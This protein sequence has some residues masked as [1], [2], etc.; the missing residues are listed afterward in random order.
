MSWSVDGPGISA[1]DSLFTTPAGHTGVTFVGIAG[2][3]GTFVY[4]GSSPNVLAVGGTTLSL[5]AAGNYGGETVWNDGNGG[6]SGGGGPDPNYPVKPGPDVAYNAG[7]PVWV[8]DS[9]GSNS[10]NL[11]LPAVGTSAG[12]PQW[13]ALIAIADQG[14]ALN[15]VSSLDGATQTIPMLNNLN[16]CR[17]SGKHKVCRWH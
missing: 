8:Y 12:A 10:Q 7:T 6:D 5:D 9:F 13:A 17:E 14:L 16:S 15:G 3:G 4:P 11:G 1:N 2:D